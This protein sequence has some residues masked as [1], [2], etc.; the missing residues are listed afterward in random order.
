MTVARPTSF[1]TAFSASWLDVIQ[2][3]KSYTKSDPRDF[4][5]C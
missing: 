5:V 4:P 2:P 3:E 1:T